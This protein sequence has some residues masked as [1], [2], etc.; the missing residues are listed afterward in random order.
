MHL[1]AGNF[2]IIQICLLLAA[3]SVIGQSVAPTPKGAPSIILPAPT[4]IPAETLALQTS[5]QT[6]P[7]KPLT[8]D[9]AIRLALTQ[10]SNYK[11]AQITEQIAA[12]DIR[13]AKAA[14]YPRVAL[15][16]NVIYTTPSLGKT[17]TAGVTEGNFAAISSRPPSFLGANAVSE[18]QALVTTTGEIDTS[19]K[20]KATLRRSRFLLESAR[21]GSEI[22]RR[23]LVQAVT[24]AYF[25]LAL[26]ATKRNGATN[27]LQTASEFENNIKLQLDAGE[28]A[29]VDLVRARLQTAQRTDELAQAQSDESVAADNLR[30]LVGYGFTQNII[31]EDLM[32]QLPGAGEIEIYT[33]TAIKTRP[34][35]AQ[36]EAD[37]QA[38]EL[39]VKIAQTERRPQ[40]N[41]SVSTGFISDSLFPN[42]VKNG[43]GAQVSVGVN[44][45]L[46][47]KGASRSRETQARLRLQQ[48]ENTRLLAERQL[49]QAFF[50][51]RTQAVSAAARIR[52]LAAS[53][54]DAEKNVS[55]S[56]ARYQAGEASI[57]EATDAQNLLITLRQSLYQAIFDYQ[58]ARARLLRAS[59]Q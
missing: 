2:L 30:F 16:P 13:Q 49:A 54:T 12:E 4:N 22:A 51:A 34:E 25:N 46:F 55:A 40:F 14:F 9:E 5:K 24:E 39:D 3:L 17:V 6:E 52:Q 42:S 58:T 11:A 57:I 7:A 35:F 38:A 59:G 26:A 21:L 27:N 44:L 41:Y 50:T 15:A 19:G 53:I 33:E 18:F 29:P 56:L 20:L 32:M 45:P 23:E 48:A 36:F 1:T 37:R 28:V 10:A 47:D 31:T 43:L 8:L